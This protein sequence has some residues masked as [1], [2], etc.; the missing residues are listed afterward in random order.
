MTADAKL[1]RVARKVRPL[2]G[3]P[4]FWDCQ[5]GILNVWVFANSFEEAKTHV[6]VI[7][8][9]LPY[10]IVGDHAVVFEAEGEADAMSEDATTRKG[11][12]QRETLARE[13]G[14]SMLLLM[15]VV[16]ADE[17]DFEKIEL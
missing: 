5:F 8:A 1:F 7:V 17:G 16:G 13:S 14:L 9:E 3:H 2:P 11:F 12:A 10:E 4:R 15:V 6:D